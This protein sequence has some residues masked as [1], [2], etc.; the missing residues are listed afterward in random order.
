MS[1]PRQGGGDARQGGGDA[2]QRG[3]RTFRDLKMQL[4]SLL[5]ILALA[6][7]AFSSPVQPQRA[8]KVLS[9]R[10]VAS[11]TI[12]TTFQ[13]LTTQLT[14]QETALQNALAQVDTS[15]ATQVVQVVKPILEAIDDDINAAK[16]T[17]ALR[18]RK[19]Q[20]SDVDIDAIAQD[21]ADAISA[22]LSALSPLE[23]LID[24]LPILGSL[25][26]PFLSPINI[27]LAIVLSGVAL[28]LSGVLALVG[29]LLSALGGALSGLGLT[30]VTGLLGL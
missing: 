18:L 12:S 2:R 3:I 24:E 29:D 27:D 8:A 20:T 7:T 1:T 25:L 9:R 14:A 30:S 16:S 6:T 19:R 23:D 15:N 28:V 13:T 21:I 22:L 5:P 4:I 26:A 17:L 11:D 10:A